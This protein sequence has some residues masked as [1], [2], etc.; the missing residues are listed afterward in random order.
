MESLIP[1][2]V[3]SEHRGEGLPDGK[4]P[5]M[6]SEFTDRVREALEA[7]VIRG[8]GHSL[9]YT[10]FYEPYFTAEELRKAKLV[11]KHKSDG[12]HKGS[13]FDTEGN[14]VKELEAVYNLD[15]L[16]WVARKV[17]ATEY[18]WAEGRGTRAEQW[19]GIIREAIA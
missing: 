1:R 16:S 18:P 13:I 17:G 10:A 14:L 9:F 19:V 7:G 5:V 6:A 3:Q 15:F 4:G 8:D 11:R 12:T 2:V